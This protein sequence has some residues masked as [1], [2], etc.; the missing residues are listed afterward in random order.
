MLESPSVLLKGL[1]GAT[2]GVWIAHGEGRCY[3][4]DDAQRAMVEANNLAP[5]RY[6]DDAG[7]PT[8]AYPFCPNGAALG[9]AALCSPCGR[10]LA[11]M[12]HPE[13]CVLPW[14]WPYRRPR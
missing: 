1:A 5:I 12:P 14:Q 4:P 7:A 6:A 11:L 13:R 3:F 2:L 10:H 9:A 8:A